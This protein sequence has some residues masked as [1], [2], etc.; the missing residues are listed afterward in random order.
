VGRASSVFVT[1]TFLAA[2][3]AL[4]APILDGPVQ[5]FLE[6]R[7]PHAPNEGY[8]PL[9]VAVHNRD[10]RRRKLKLTFTSVPVLDVTRTVLLDPGERRTVLL[11][12]PALSR[13]GNLTAD[14]EGPNDPRPES[15]SWPYETAPVILSDGSAERAAGLLPGLSEGMQNAN[16]VEPSPRPLMRLPPLAFPEDLVGYV[17]F[18]GVALIDTPFEELLE[19]QRRAIEAYAATGGR[20]LL[21][22][23]PAIPETYFPLLGK[24]QGPA[25]NPYGFGVLHLCPAASCKDETAA[26]LAATGGQGPIDRVA[27]TREP[28]RYNPASEDVLVEVA[29]APVG[30]FVLIVLCFAVIIG[31]GSFAMRRRYGPGALLLF[32][33]GIALVTCSGIAG[34]GAFREGMFTVHARSIAITLLEE[35]HHRATTVA[36]TGY[37]ASL[38]PSEVRFD[39]QSA[40]LISGNSGSPGWKWRG[41]ELD[42][43]SGLSFGAGFLP[44][45][46]YRE[47]LSMGVTSSRARFMVRDGEEEGAVVVSNALGSGVVSG[48]ARLGERHCVFGALEDGAKKTVACDADGSSQD[49]AIDAMT[50]QVS[51]RFF[52]EK[53]GHVLPR[54]E[55][56]EYLVLLDRAVFAPSG[57]IR[58]DRKSDV[59]LVRGRVSR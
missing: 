28:S 21:V 25:A 35:E 26:F 33:P 11:H 15:L 52:T 24:R 23:P 45:R 54:L 55:D 13:Y 32:I 29:R 19:P 18:A 6:Q 46:S 53:L 47:Y 20:V 48:T 59:Q 8:I 41:L 30:S 27:A 5:V 57:N 49:R 3:P 31:P 43:T 38:A 36:V 34:Y 56:G 40:V 2:T 50:R 44:S 51:P 22:R 16:A 58:L 12:V 7:P 39:G 9:S 10:A 37:Y 17:G 4:A 14:A 42:Q 1:L